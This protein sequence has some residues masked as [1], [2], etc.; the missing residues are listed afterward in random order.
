VA[1]SQFTQCTLF[2][3][4]VASVKLPLRKS[5]P[6]IMSASRH[7]PTMRGVKASQYRSGEYQGTAAPPKWRRRRVTTA[8]WPGVR[9]R[10]AC[11]SVCLCVYVCACQLEVGPMGKRGL[12]SRI[13][14]HVI[15]KRQH[16]CLGS[17]CGAPAWGCPG[18]GSRQLLLRGQHQGH[19]LCGRARWPGQL[20]ATLC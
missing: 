1:S 4:A 13:E 19:A 3:S 17:L 8:R 10:G 5:D 6:V 18:A 2:K 11:A 20:K 15:C 9:G 14:K 12:A 7:H 16:M